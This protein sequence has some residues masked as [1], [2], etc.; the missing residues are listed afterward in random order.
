MIGT[1][2][3]YTAVFGGY[4][5]V[6]PSKNKEDG[7]D[8]VLLTDE[9]TE[10]DGWQRRYPNRVFRNNP[11]KESRRCKILTFRYFPEADFTI[12][13][14]GNIQLKQKPSIVIDEMLKDADIA[15]F[16]HPHRNCLYQEARIC[17]DWRLD[18]PGIIDRQMRKYRLEEYPANHGLSTCWFII[19]RNTEKVRWFDSLWWQ[20]V[21]NHSIRD[22][23]SFDYIRWKTGLK[24][25]WI[26]GDLLNHPW[27]AR[28]SHK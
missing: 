20:E 26:P 8:Y 21:Y 12:W 25:R 15:V 6:R 13:H 27:I 22:Q 4:D 2:V 28:F 16:K 9:V 17:M 3:V 23:L 11:R 18:N 14:G 7:V 5:Y 19:R 10:S 1:T 24:V